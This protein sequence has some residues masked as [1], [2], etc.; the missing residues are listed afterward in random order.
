MK[1]LITIFIIS[2]ALTS[3]SNNNSNI[4]QNSQN[5]TKTTTETTNIQEPEQTPEKKEITFSEVKNNL[6]KIKNANPWDLEMINNEI[7][8]IYAN[9]IKKEAEEKKD[10][11]IC[12]KLNDFEKQNCKREVAYKIS[13]KNGDAQFCDKLENKNDSREC[14][15]SVYRELAKQKLDE[16]L[17]DKLDFWN[18]NNSLS[19]E[20]KEFNKDEQLREI[21]NCKN[22]VFE[23]KAAKNTDKTLC[24]KITDKSEKDMCLTRV[25]DEIQMKNEKVEEQE[26]NDTNK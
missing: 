23:E 3:C 16:S 25:N 6:E 1:K 11:S 7:N 9:S 24:Q 19:K 15:N 13:L 20:E 10:L 5:N 12:D 22:L 14:K 18:S 26:N 17:C 2:L 8:N 4:K 21:N